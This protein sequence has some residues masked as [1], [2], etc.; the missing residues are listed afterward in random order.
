MTDS[1]ITDAFHALSVADPEY[2]LFRPGLE[3]ARLSEKFNQIPRYL[4][5]VFTPRSRGKTNWTWTK[6][7]DAR[8]GNRNSKVDIFARENRAEVAGMLYRHLRWW[9]GPEDNFVSWTS[10]LLF[11]LVYIFHLRAN[12]RNGSAFDNI[13]LC[14][15]DTTE[16]PKEVF[17]Q[18]LDLIQAYLGYSDDLKISMVSERRM[19]TTRESTYLKVH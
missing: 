14:I 4:F 15:I 18:D 7:M 9:Q 8:G 11:A 13:F 2:L 16:F 10:S 19:A 5:R 12:T 17:M 6:S 1:E 3:N